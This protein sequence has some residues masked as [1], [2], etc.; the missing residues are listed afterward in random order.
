GSNDTIQFDPT[1]FGSTQQ[2]ILL[3]GS[4]LLLTSSVSIAGP[5]AGLLAISGNGQSR[6]FEV[7]AGAS[8]TISGLTVENGAAAVGGGGGILNFGNLNI[9]GCMLSGNSAIA[10]GAL[11]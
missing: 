2:T 9:S 10:G 4:E 5:G 11:F 1:A 6:V 7:A 8:D 3:G